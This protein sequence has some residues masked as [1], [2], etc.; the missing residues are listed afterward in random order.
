MRTEVSTFLVVVFVG[1]VGSVAMADPAPPTPSGD[2]STNVTPDPSKVIICH[3]TPPPVGS[4]LGGGRVCKTKAEWDQES[5]NA[6]D[7]LSKEGSLQ[8]NRP[9]GGH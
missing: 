8:A 5:Q 3:V 1:L 9:A 2:T 6:Q 7:Y 4:H